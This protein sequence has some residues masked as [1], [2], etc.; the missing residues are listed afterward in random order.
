MCKRLRPGLICL[1]S[2]LV[3][4][5]LSFDTATADEKNSSY[6]RPAPIKPRLFP[7]PSLK[8]CLADMDSCATDL[9]PDCVDNGAI[10][11]HYERPGPF[12]TEANTRWQENFEQ[13][14]GKLTYVKINRTLGA[15]VDNLLSGYPNQPTVFCNRPANHLRLGDPADSQPFI[16][17]SDFNPYLTQPSALSVLQRNGAHIYW[18]SVPEFASEA[19]EEGAIPNLCLEWELLHA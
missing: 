9:R 10:C 18:S 3:F 7:K 4:F 13:R 16:A 15:A 12:G 5:G 14:Y 6:P 19:N 1:F 11:L 17:W 2:V 8:N